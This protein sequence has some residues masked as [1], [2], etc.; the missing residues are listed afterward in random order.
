MHAEATKHVLLGR[1]SLG[2]PAAISRSGRN[3]RGGKQTWGPEHNEMAAVSK[4]RSVVKSFDG[5]T[6]EADLDSERGKADDVEEETG[7]C[8]SRD[9]RDR[10]PGTQGRIHRDNV[11]KVPPAAGAG[12]NLQRLLARGLGRRR[13][14]RVGSTNESVR[15]MTGE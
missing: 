8:T 9:R 2:C 12:S 3:D 5:K 10:G 6:R 13:G 11:G 7:M 14:E 15:A 4:K 1:K